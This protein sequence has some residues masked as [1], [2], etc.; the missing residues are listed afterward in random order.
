MPRQV[1]RRAI[2]ASMAASP[3]LA[4]RARRIPIGLELFSVRAEL[5]QDLFGTV[6]AVARMGYDGVEFFSPYFS[7]TPEYAKGVRKLLDETGLKCWST[8]NGANSFSAENLPKAIEL[9]QIIGSRSIVMAGAGRVSG[10]DGWRGVAE[11]LTQAAEKLRPIGMRAG[12][13]NHQTEFRA[14]DGVRPMDV[15][16]EGTPKD[17]TL[18]LDVGTCLEAGA[19][20]VAWINAH[21]GR[22]HSIHCKDWSPDKQ[23]GYRVL[24]GEGAAPWMNIFEAAEKT[25]G[26]E[27]YLI[28]QEGS[29]YPPF[30][31]AERCLATIRKM[32]A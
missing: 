8:H 11:R 17:V 26:I 14:V 27:Y 24:F 18:Q 32:R 7:W 20:P 2:V 12:F 15:L 29:D 5:A 31:T 13:H 21:P 23:K 22:I 28:E 16:A 6:R 9:N 4:Q 10:T 30:E 19:D 3:L 25:G 1:S